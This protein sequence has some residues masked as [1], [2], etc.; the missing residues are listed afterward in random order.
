MEPFE[1]DR[2]DQRSDEQRIAQLESDLQEAR[3]ELERVRAQ[4]ADALGTIRNL[5]T[6]PAPRCAHRTV[7]SCGECWDCGAII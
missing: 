3:A 4:L 7:N 1:T 5:T 2:F 6:P